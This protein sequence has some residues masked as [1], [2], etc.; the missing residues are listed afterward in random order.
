MKLLD[1]TNAYFIALS[2]IIFCLG[3]VLFYILFQF[4]IDLDYDNKLHER[5]NYTIKQL[6]RSDSLMLYQKYSQNIITLRPIAETKDTAE[7][8]TDTIIFDRVEG[9]QI[10]FR[11][12]AFNTKI[13]GRYYNIQVRRSNVERNPLIKGVVVLVF[14]LFVSFVATLAA[15]NRKLSIVIWKP[16][17]AMLDI[18][19]KYKVDRAESLQLPQSSIDEFNK[20]SQEV[21]KMTSK[22]HREFN[23]QKEFIENASHE[24]QTPL[25]IINNK[26][27]ILLQAPGLKH[28]QLELINSSRIAVKRLSKLSEALLILSRIDNRQFHHV[29]NVCINDYVGRHLTALEELISMQSITVQ[30]QNTNVISVM[31]NPFLADMLLENLLTN[32]I[33]HNIAGGSI[34]LT[35]ENRTLTIANHGEQPA[36]DPLKYFQRF[37]RSNKKSSSLGL[38][39]SIVKGICETYQ[40]EI[41]YRFKNS[42]HEISIAFA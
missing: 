8:I 27:E 20:L 10:S 33:R 29:E 37:T 40:F 4:I 14:V 42:V 7:I 30:F 19:N 6:Q 32:A 1:K 38:G 16:F 39:L 35:L 17:Y 5:R 3:G 28:E 15:V 2:L 21:E 18:I 22:I 26:L 9:K 11:Q 23:I 12:L 25:A 13:R 41:N 34:F 24:I 31:M 36:E